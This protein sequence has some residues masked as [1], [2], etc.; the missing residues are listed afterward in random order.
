MPTE[1][2]LKYPVGR[3]QIVPST[4]DHRMHYIHQLRL[5][6]S[7]LNDAVKDLKE[8]QLLSTYRPGGWTL[9]Q[10]VHHVVESDVNA[11]PRLKYALTQDIPD[12]MIAQQ[13]LWA[14]LPDAQSPNI[15]SSLTL[16][17]AI[18]HRWADAF[19]SLRPEDFGRQW[20]HNRYGLLTIDALLQQYV[21]HAQHHAAQISEH[22][23][24][25]GW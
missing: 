18:R 17:E 23:K 1:E 25:M 13:G 5:A 10:V 19:E 11:Y 24:R 16:F 21:W 2:E 22:R 8:N 4:P 9:A 3:F 6:P 12:A 20:R 14:E 15:S 7:I